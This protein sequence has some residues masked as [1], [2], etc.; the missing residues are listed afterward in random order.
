M[1]GLAHAERLERGCHVVA[2]A[3]DDDR[4][5]LR[6][7]RPSSWIGAASRSSGSGGSGRSGGSRG[8][9]RSGGFGRSG[10]SGRSAGL[11]RSGGRRVSKRRVVFRRRA[12]RDPHRRFFS[13]LS[14]CS[15]V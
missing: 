6:A 8:W 13:A 7:D 15:A 1:H 2:I 5:H 12:R 11:A 9:V 10:G 14:A 4:F 3:D